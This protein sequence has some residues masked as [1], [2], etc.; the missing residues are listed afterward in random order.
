MGKP[1][2]IVEKSSEECARENMVMGGTETPSVRKDGRAMGVKRT[3]KHY[4]GQ[5]LLSTTD[6]K[7]PLKTM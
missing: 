1:R 4:Y 2:S 6:L 7:V 3:V 5:T